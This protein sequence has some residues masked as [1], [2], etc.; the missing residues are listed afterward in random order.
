MGARDKVFIYVPCMHQ[1]QSHSVKP[2]S[3]NIFTMHPAAHDLQQEA[4]LPA[5]QVTNDVQHAI[6]GFWI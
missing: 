6:R 2:A 1:S 4:V 3:E 5:G